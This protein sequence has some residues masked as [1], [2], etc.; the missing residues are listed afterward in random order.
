MNIASSTLTIHRL[1]RQL[2]TDYSSD[3]VHEYLDASNE[4]SVRVSKIYRYLMFVLSIFTL[5]A[6]FHNLSINFEGEANSRAEILIPTGVMTA[7]F[8]LAYCNRGKYEDDAR[9]AIETVENAKKANERV[10]TRTLTKD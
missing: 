3:H 4:H 1:R 2:F 6:L 5:I 7:V 9:R 10:G 8:A